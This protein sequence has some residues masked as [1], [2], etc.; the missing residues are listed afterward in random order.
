ME[1]SGAI[2]EPSGGEGGLQTGDVQGVD[3]GRHCNLCLAPWSAELG[4]TGRASG[5]GQ[6][7]QVWNLPLHGWS[8]GIISEVLRPAGELMAISQATTTHK[9]FITA[10]VRRRA[11]VSLPLAIDVSLRMRRY[12]V[13]ITGD[14]GLFPVFLQELGRYAFP[15]RKKGLVSGNRGGGRALLELSRDEKGKRILGHAGDSGSGREPEERAMNTVGAT[16]VGTEQT[17]KGS[18][19][20]E[21][22]TSSVSR[23]EI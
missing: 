5:D 11:G 9:Q 14:R 21:S 6:W 16:A 2:G 1:F 4:A 23:S 7:M 10:L 19:D 13:I 20:R 3:E 8:W 17:C 18:L 15:K 12:I 22:F